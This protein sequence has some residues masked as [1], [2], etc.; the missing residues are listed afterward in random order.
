M[1]GSVSS[2]C[3]TESMC[4]VVVV[5][6]VSSLL[7][8]VVSRGLRVVRWITA[9]EPRDFRTRFDLLDRT[10]SDTRDTHTDSHSGQAE[11]HHY[12]LGVCT[13]TTRR[14]PR[15]ALAARRGATPTADRGR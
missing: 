8:S 9:L 11:A 13:S 6:F 15:T 4:D 7:C 5:S 1:R 10:Q 2:T 14:V 3:V 12:P